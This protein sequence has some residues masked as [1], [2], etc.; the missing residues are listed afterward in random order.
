MRA[1]I[2][3]HRFVFVAAVG[4]LVLSGPL[5]TWADNDDEVILTQIGL[6]QG[7]FDA[8]AYQTPSSADEILVTSANLSTQSTSA[9]RLD[10]NLNVQGPGIPVVT[11]ATMP[12][13][14]FCA[15]NS[16]GTVTCHLQEF[17]FLP[18]TLSQKVET[19]WFDPG[20]VGATLNA[21]GFFRGDS[22]LAASVTKDFTSVFTAFAN[23]NDGPPG[24]QI[25]ETGTPGGVTET[26]SILFSDPQNIPPIPFTSIDG[27]PVVAL[28]A[29]TT[30]DPIFGSGLD[31]SRIDSSGKFV[32]S[33][34][35]SPSTERVTGATTVEVGD[36]QHTFY[37]Q[38]PPNGFG[39]ELYHAIS[40]NSG[41][42]RLSILKNASEVAAIGVIQAAVI[43]GNIKVAYA[44]APEGTPQIFTGVL[45]ADGGQIE[46]FLPITSGFGQRNRPSIVEVGDEV[47]IFYNINGQV[48]YQLMGA[49]AA[50]DSGSLGSFGFGDGMGTL[51]ENGFSVSSNDPSNTASLV[52]QGGGNGALQFNLQTTGSVQVQTGN[53]ALPINFTD[54]LQDLRFD[55]SA[56]TDDAEAGAKL[57]VDVTLTKSTDPS[58][59]L[60]VGTKVFQ[61]NQLGVLNLTGQFSLTPTL[62][63]QAKDL[64]LDSY[65]LKLIASTDT[66]PIILLD[67]F[68][69]MG[70]PAVLLGDAN[71]DNQVTGA[72]LIAVQQNFGKDYTNGT[73]DGLGL[74][75]ASDDC[76]VT[77]SDL[78]AV[79][80]NFGKALVA[81]VPEPAGLWLAF[82][83]YVSARGRF[84][85][86]T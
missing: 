59:M 30:G 4:I 12:T 53:L 57:K 7:P 19:F 23:F 84:R 8:V 73:C 64:N 85:P 11:T 28:G 76:L 43:N 38:V 18:P 68:V 20:N 75:D 36:L 82:V 44:A 83:V 21:D 62:K 41:I 1:H 81:A 74:G 37:V 55:L 3:C 63:Q 39:V 40:D 15:E 6:N 48:A 70:L 79:Q 51:Q 31:I 2:A 42:Q 71:N 45:S 56:S 26:D 50:G 54:K 24:Y 78:I 25:Y 52:D 66:D 14:I 80:Q 65:M 49:P 16:N 5:V 69:F 72:D 58:A 61:L 27:D 60:Q 67:D 22:Q 10:A 77:G 34:T 13:G 35:L 47:A 46:P 9:F 32:A 17:S 33:S 86:Y 29:P